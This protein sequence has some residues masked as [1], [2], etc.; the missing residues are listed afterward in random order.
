MVLI[1]VEDRFINFAEEYITM[2][3]TTYISPSPYQ[4]PKNVY[5]AV[6]WKSDKGEVRKVLYELEPNNKLYIYG[7]PVRY[8]NT[9]TREVYIRDAFGKYSNSTGIY[10]TAV[11]RN[12][13]VIAPR[14]DGT[15]EVIDM[16]SKYGTSSVERYAIT[17]P[18]TV[19]IEGLNF[20]MD[21]DHILNTLGNFMPTQE[22]AIR[23]RDIKNIIYG[24]KVTEIESG[25][26]ARTRLAPKALEGEYI[27]GRGIV[28]G[29]AVDILI[30][31]L[32]YK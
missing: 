25:K 9:E 28:S 19:K 1:T 21:L 16:G 26:C 11:S 29:P 7:Q 18:R 17:G 24:G 10:N 12:H 32:G 2:A 6:M 20:E 3:S 13:L 8:G 23:D 14:P 15:I 27:P 22:F 30:C 5:V 31:N 4:Q